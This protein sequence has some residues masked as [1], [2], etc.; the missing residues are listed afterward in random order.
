M[1]D[2]L[3]LIITQLGV[4]TAGQKFD[5]PQSPG[6]TVALQFHKWTLPALDDGDAEGKYFPHVVVRVMRGKGQARADEIT[7]RLEGGLYANTTEVAG[8]A[9]AVRL[10]EL[11]L[12]IGGKR[13]FTP[14]SLA[15]PIS[16]HLGD[17]Q[18]GLHPHPYY[19]VTVDLPFTRAATA[20][21]RR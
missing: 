16:W 20:T 17:E 14:Y 15:D 13:S 21:K 18:Y 8:N 9:D 12:D 2:L 1:I 10:L 3:D 4:L 7:V 6:A 19:Y 5:N 11:L